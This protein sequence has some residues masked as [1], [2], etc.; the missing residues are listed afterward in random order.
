M[1]DRFPPPNKIL[2]VLVNISQ[3]FYCREE[4]WAMQELFIKKRKKRV[5]KM[6]KCLNYQNN[7][8]LDARLKKEKIDE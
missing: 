7:G 6:D 4:A 1:F 2:Q 3:K 8:Y 5:E